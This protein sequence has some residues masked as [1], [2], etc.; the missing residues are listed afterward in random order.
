MSRKEAVWGG[1][2]SDTADKSSAKVNRPSERP[3]TAST[4]TVLGFFGEANSV[5]GAPNVCDGFSPLLLGRKGR[6][7]DLQE[8]LAQR[9]MMMGFD[10]RPE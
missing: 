1:P 5:A 7:S 9:R 4:Y 2:E 6:C 3:D 8:R 10:L